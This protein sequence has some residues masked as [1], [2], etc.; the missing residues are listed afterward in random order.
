MELVRGEHVRPVC[1]L[2]PSRRYHP[3]IQPSYNTSSFGWNPRR[4]TLEMFDP[5]S[6]FIIAR[7]DGNVRAYTIFRFDR[8]DSQDVV[9]WCVCVGLIVGRPL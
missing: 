6:R 7:L 8:E 3:F 5:Q 9:Y 4:K 2:S 1:G